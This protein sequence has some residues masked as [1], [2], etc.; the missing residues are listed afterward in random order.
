MHGKTIIRFVAPPAQQ[1][2]KRISC[3]IGDQ[4]LQ[5]SLRVYIQPMGIFQ[6]QEQRLLQALRQDQGFEGLQSILETQ[7]GFQALVKR[8]FPIQIHQSPQ[9]RASAFELAAQQITAQICLGGPFQARQQIIQ[10][11]IELLFV[12]VLR[13]LS[14]LLEIMVQKAL[15][16]MQRLA[17]DRLRQALE[18]AHLIFRSPH[19]LQALAQLVNQA[20]FAHPGLAYHIHNSGKPRAGQLTA[21]LQT[22]WAVQ[23]WPQQQ[24]KQVL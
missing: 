17:Q 23:N 3:H 8:V 10:H 16:G 4:R 1:H 6:V 13:M 22:R 11:Q 24:R 2:S 18:P 12:L 14:R 7:L 19:S 15:E 9:H 5:Q 21:R 20:A